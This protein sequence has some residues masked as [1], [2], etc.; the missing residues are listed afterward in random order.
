MYRTQT[1]PG[2]NHSTEED[3]TEVVPDLFHIQCELD[4]KLIRFDYVEHWLSLQHD[5]IK[6]VLKTL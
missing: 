1:G 2:V 3:C 5:I 4:I 6:S